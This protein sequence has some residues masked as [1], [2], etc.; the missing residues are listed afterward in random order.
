MKMKRNNLIGNCLIVICLFLLVVGASPV[1]SKALGHSISRFQ[2]SSN[3]GGDAKVSGA[4][5]FSAHS[6]TTADGQTR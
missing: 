3:I 5:D 2:G 1:L 6:S 4:A